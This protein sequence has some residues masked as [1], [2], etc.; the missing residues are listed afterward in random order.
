MTD[1][2]FPHL[3][4]PLTI[5]GREIRNR[6]VSTGHDTCLPEHGLVNEAYIAYQEARAKGGAGLI[7][8]QVAGVHETAR[9]TSHLIMA[10]TDDCIPGYAELARRCHRHGARVVSQL[11]HPGREIMES[12]NG[13]L[14]VAY[15]ASGTPN[16]RFR[17]MPREMDAAMIAE[18]TQGYAD[19]AQRMYRAG[20][21]GVELV[22]SHGYLPAQFL[23]PRVN[24]RQDEYG[25]S[26]DNRLKFMADVLEAMR[27]ATGDDFIIGLRISAS[28]KDEAGLTNAE[29]LA[30]AKGLGARIDYLSVTIGTSATIGGA[31]HIAP[32]MN[33]QA[34]YTA[35]EA[36]AF[37]TALQVPVF[38][39]G[40]INQPQE[41]ELVIARGEA[42]GC[43][44]TRALICDPE[45]PVKADQGRFDDIRAC[46][47]CNQACIHHFHRGLP[48]SCIQHPETGRETVFGSHPVTTHPRKI[49]V[50]GGGPA[51]LKAAA[52]AAER[53]HHVTLFEAE[54]RLGGQALLAQ[55]LPH[56]AEF[57]GIVTNLTR[58]C[59]LAGVTIRKNT[60]VD[61]S[62]LHEF[63]PDAVVLATGATPYL[64]PFET[65]GE[66]RV[67][68]AWQILRREVKPGARVVVADWRADWIGP[69]VAE[70]LARDGAGVDLAVNGLYM[71][72]AMPFYVRDA[73]AAS[74]H[75]LG[76]RVTPYARLIGTFGDTV[77]LQHTASELP[78]EIEG[79]DMLVLSSGHL[80]FDGLRSEI[81]A[82]GIEYHGIGDCETPR[83]A[84]EAVYEGMLAGRAL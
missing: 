54:P 6:I 30:A 46:I 82:L 26:D 63:A 7:V 50:I 18:I 11:F 73:T 56:R 53:G 39:T 58:E 3:F 16:E 51:G 32:P 21:D 70:A 1:A 43:G 15:S 27:A 67:A 57:G 59:A 42:D 14:A 33:F 71:G 78:I 75:R 64:P 22:A 79:V 77:F 10:T 4:R 41:A 81:T 2:M 17:N 45:M 29:T 38:I 8:T 69:G 13:M 72:E 62:L 47:G 49:M 60:R 24:R 28:E 23:N 52:V 68:T 12:A 37:K 9:Y 5:R 80:P 66:I 61:A 36:R 20:L 65:D 40:R 19:A 44:M 76:V 25:G 34:A 84:E 74:L 83:T 55:L 35:P 48:I 31:V